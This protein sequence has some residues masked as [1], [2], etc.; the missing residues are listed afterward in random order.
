MKTVS[1]VAL[2]LILTGCQQAPHFEEGAKL[3]MRVDDSLAP[4]A[5]IRHD[6]VVIIDR[7]LQTDKTG[8][9]AI[10][11]HGARRNPTGTLKIIAQIRNRTTFPQVIEAR[12]NFFDNGFVPIE[13]TTAWSRV[14]LDPNGI[15]VYEESS[16]MAG[17]VAHYY[18]EIREAR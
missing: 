8:K 16:V 1:F 14:F 17:E 7:A 10:E 4:D 18:V 5:R 12:T 6:Q 13:K 15:G 2:A 11:S 9:L 3:G